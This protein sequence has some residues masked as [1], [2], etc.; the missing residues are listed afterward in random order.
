MAG[1]ELLKGYNQ[2]YNNLDFTIIRFFNTYGEGQVAQFVLTKWVRSVL[3]GK[4][5]IVYGDGNQIRSYGHVEDSVTGIKLIIEKNISNGKVYN[6]GNSTQVRTLIELAQEVIDI[7]S[8]DKSLSVE[9]LGGFDGS[10]RDE[11]REINERFCDTSLAMKDLGY[12]PKISIKQGI[13]RIARQPN[14]YKD[15]PVV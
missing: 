7:V 15:W 4:N 9:V 14:I 5:P 12:N 3:N 11:S 6:I 1:E 10:D 2:Y 8:P 13:M